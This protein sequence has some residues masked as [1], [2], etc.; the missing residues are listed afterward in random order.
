MAVLDESDG[1]FSCLLPNMYT[2][3]KQVNRD[4]IILYIS[5]TGSRMTTGIV[6]PWRVEHM[7]HHKFTPEDY[8]DFGF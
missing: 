6:C 4:L 3:K 8:E 1:R 2:W 7:I 5:K